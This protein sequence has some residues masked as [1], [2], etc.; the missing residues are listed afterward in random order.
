MKNVKRV[1]QSQQADIIR[2][3]VNEATRHESLEE[4]EAAPIEFL[5]HEGVGASTLSPSKEVPYKVIAMGRDEED[6][7]VLKH[8]LGHMALHRGQALYSNR[9]FT[10]VIQSEVEAE[11]YAAKR[12]GWDKAMMGRVAELLAALDTQDNRVNV[13]LKAAKRVGLTKADLPGLYVG[14]LAAEDSAFG[15]YGVGIRNQFEF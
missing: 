10:D 6:P 12:W 3:I 8:E 5:M 15:A 1:Q 14:L 7:S 4:A 9:P 13:A 2:F 11:L